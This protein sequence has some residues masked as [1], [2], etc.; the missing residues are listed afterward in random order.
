MTLGGFFFHA[1]LPSVAFLLSFS[2]SSAWCSLIKV[3]KP[4]GWVRRS[5]GNCGRPNTPSPR[6]FIPLF[7]SSL[8]PTFSPCC[9]VFHPLSLSFLSFFA[10][11]SSAAL[12]CVHAHLHADT[13]S[14][15]PPPL[16]RVTRVKVDKL[17]LQ[18][19]LQRRERAVKLLPVND[20]RT[21]RNV[22]GK[23]S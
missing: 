6:H 9:T 22:C 15:L 1:L 2:H 3:N 21:E 12:P 4:A 11:V 5:R 16:E 19:P 7:Y 13:R 8:R 10:S 18:N 23:I 20:T 14:T 17:E